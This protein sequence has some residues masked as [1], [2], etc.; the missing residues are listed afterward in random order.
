MQYNLLNTTD[1]GLN[2]PAYSY[3]HWSNGVTLGFSTVPI[4]LNNGASLGVYFDMYRGGRI[5]KDFY[6]SDSYIMPGSGFMKFGLIS[7]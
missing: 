5:Y 4:Q 1:T 2:L 3:K 7:K 6:N